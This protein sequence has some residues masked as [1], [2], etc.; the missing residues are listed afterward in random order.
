MN[1][2]PAAP[3][4]QQ[5]SI[6]IALQTGER[7]DISLPST[8]KGKVTRGLA[9]KTSGLG[10]LPIPTPKKRILED[11]SQSQSPAMKK[12][13][14]ESLKFRFKKMP[15]T[16]DDIMEDVSTQYEMVQDD[17]YDDLNQENV[18]DDQAPLVPEGQLTVS[19]PSISSDMENKAY[20]ANG[21]MHLINQDQKLQEKLSTERNALYRQ[22]LDK[23]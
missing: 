13:P 14:K 12:V 22:L 2:I 17:D 23:L 16:S 1:G 21:I 8:S 6:A 19:K 20:V 9:T 3:T 18:N 15:K 11:I 10:L 5:A 7:Y 4:A